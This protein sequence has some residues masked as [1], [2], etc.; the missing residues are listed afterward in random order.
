MTLDPPIL[1]HYTCDH[2]AASIRA[3]GW[4]LP[5]GDIAPV[6][7]APGVPSLLW[8]TDLDRPNRLAL[9]LTS[10]SISCDR[11]RYRFAIQPQPSITTWWRW[12]RAHPEF[13]PFAARIEEQPGSRPKHWW[14]SE[15]A[16]PA[17]EQP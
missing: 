15:I 4:I 13:A 7:L 16:V 3:T 9:G 12:R 6:G 14:V 8:L 10:I 11:T 17:L 2:G 5:L 1:Y